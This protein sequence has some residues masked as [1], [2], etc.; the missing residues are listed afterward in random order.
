MLVSHSCLCKCAILFSSCSI[1]MPYSLLTMG[2]SF[3]IRILQFDTGL[4]ARYH[5]MLY[6]RQYSAIS[7]I[8][9]IKLMDQVRGDVWPCSVM[10]VVALQQHFR[11]V[12]PMRISFSSRLVNSNYWAVCEY[13]SKYRIVVNIILLRH[14]QNMHR[15]EGSFSQPKTEY[16]LHLSQATN[17]VT[18][19]DHLQ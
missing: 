14:W 16:I 8:D 10:L 1:T 2:T 13:E 18:I 4:E 11:L 12:V 3:I 6:F 9:N 19:K 7:P 15:N 17:V 5:L